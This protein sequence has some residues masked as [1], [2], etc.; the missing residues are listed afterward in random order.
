MFELV[1]DHGLLVNRWAQVFHTCGVVVLHLDQGSS[2][3][4]LGTG[5]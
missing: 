5:S 2:Y 1:C 3:M 4:T